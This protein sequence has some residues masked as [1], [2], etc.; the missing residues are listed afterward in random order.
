MSAAVGMI[1]LQCNMIGKCGGKIYA[2]DARQYLHQ[3]A[4]VA[5][6]SNDSYSYP[7]RPCPACAKIDELIAQRNVD[8]EKGVD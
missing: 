8:F 1:H 6:A 2:V 7:Q 5:L 4:S 3:L